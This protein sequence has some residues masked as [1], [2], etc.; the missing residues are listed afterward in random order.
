[1]KFFNSATVTNNNTTL[2]SINTDPGVSP[3]KVTVEE[4]S[5]FKTIPVRNSTPV[6]DLTS[7]EN[8]LN[9][10]LL[11]SSIAELKTDLQEKSHSKAIPHISGKGFYYGLIGGLHMNAIKDE[12]FKKTGFDIGL[13]GGYRFSPGSFNRVRDTV[14]KEILLDLG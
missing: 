6:S 8:T 9:G 10:V 14:C 7:S 13:L 11:N 4:R 5:F 12:G 2:N 3:N 1:M